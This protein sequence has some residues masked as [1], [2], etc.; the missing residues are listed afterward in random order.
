MTV[1]IISRSI[2]MKVWDQAWIKLM[3]PGSAI[4]S[5]PIALWGP[6]HAHQLLLM[7]S[8]NFSEYQENYQKLPSIA[9]VNA[10]VRVKLSF[11]KAYE[12]EQLV[13]P[14]LIWF[15]WYGIPPRLSHIAICCL[16]GSPGTSTS[17]SV[18][19]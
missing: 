14:N 2:S 1:E 15:G 13:T 16:S 4:S 5:L 9:V 18:S 12:R 17:V 3:T 11:D 6:V 10:I 19:I 8:L 7:S